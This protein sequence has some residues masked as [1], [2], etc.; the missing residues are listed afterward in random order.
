MGEV[1]DLSAIERWLED[2]ELRDT[3]VAAGLAGLALYRANDIN[4]ALG[5]F[6]AM[7]GARLDGTSVVA[8]IL[9]MNE[10]IREYNSMMFEYKVKHRTWRKWQDRLAGIGERPVFEPDPVLASSEWFVGTWEDLSP[11]QMQAASKAYAV[12]VDNVNDRNEANRPLFEQRTSRWDEIDSHRYD[13]EPIEPV[14]PTGKVPHEVSPQGALTVAAIT[15]FLALHPEL[16]TDGIA[17]V[18]E[19]IKGI[20]E[21]VPF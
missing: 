16:V 12:Y 19:I 18:G 9:E 20:G 8:T 10:A 5:K 4:T 15:F 21:I 7:I 3:A 13:V 14:D 6:A 17:A 1:P 11:E 2:P